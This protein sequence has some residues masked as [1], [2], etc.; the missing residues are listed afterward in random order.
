MS[1]KLG[2]GLSALLGEETSLIDEVLGEQEPGQLDRQNLAVSAIFPNPEQPR[3]HFDS[4]EMQN[5]ADSIRQRGLLQ[6]ILVR[7][8]D[9][10]NYQ[11][12][13]GER[14]WRAAQLAGLHEMP[15]IILNISDKEAFEISVI[16]NAQ[17]DDLSPIEEAKSYSKLMQQ[18]EHNQ[19]TIGKMVGKSRSTVANSLRLLT[20]PDKVQ[21]MLIK[22]EIS[23]GHARNLVGKDDAEKL[24][25]QIISEKLSVRQVEN[26]GKSPTNDS[27]IENV[28]SA[29]NLKDDTNTHLEEVRKEI[30]NSLGLSVSI[31]DNKGKGQITLKYSSLEQLEGLR[32][33]LLS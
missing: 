3:Q 18:Y 19:E 7:K 24:A 33:K 16:E 4:Q 15:S 25:Q 5:L 14:R 9:A 6:P 12:I 26:I 13:A 20:L 1:E 22:R 2:R 30:E 17:R 27:N 8:D 31:K 29:K 11:I 23:A 32:H 28:K 21:E 10:E